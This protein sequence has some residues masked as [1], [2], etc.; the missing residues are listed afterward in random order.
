MLLKIISLKYYSFIHSVKVEKWIDLID[1]QNEF[2]K[3]KKTNNK[4][5]NFWIET[6]R[7]KHAKNWRIC[8][9]ENNHSIWLNPID[10]NSIKSN[11][12]I[13]LIINNKEIQFLFL[14]IRKLIDWYWFYFDQIKS[15]GI[16]LEIFFLFYKCKKKL[17][18]FDWLG[19]DIQK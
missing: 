9:Y 13:I 1:E 7:Q 14:F 10:S 12:I 15:I 5:R 4:F 11:V 18:F 19:W 2:F 3:E 16:N 17:T 6:Q 8:K